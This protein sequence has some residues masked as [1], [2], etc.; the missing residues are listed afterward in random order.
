MLLLTWDSVQIFFPPT[1]V[2][3]WHTIKKALQ[4][5]ISDLSDWGVPLT[6][7]RSVKNPLVTVGVQFRAVLLCRQP[8]LCPRVL[9]VSDGGCRSACSPL[10]QRFLGHGNTS[11]KLQLKRFY[12]CE[13]SWLNPSGC[14]LF[15]SRG[16]MSSA[17]CDYYLSKVIS[18]LLL[19]CSKGLS[20]SLVVFMAPVWIIGDC[21]SV[22][23]E[24]RRLQFWYA[25]P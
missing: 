3:K 2:L 12:S 15:Y 20:F 11:A 21:S 17:T 22:P 4:Y 10:M 1:S 9:R 5:N 16:V 18:A 23:N 7:S 25:E 6:W 19:P 13:W 24:M 8:L 14:C